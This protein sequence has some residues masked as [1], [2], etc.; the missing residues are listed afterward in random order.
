MDRMPVDELLYQLEVDPA[1]LILF[2]EGVRDQRF[3]SVLVPFSERINA[4]VYSIDAID[5]QIPSGGA[6]ERVLELARSTS[7]HVFAARMLFFLDAD[8][9][10][11][12]GRQLPARVITTDW[13]DMEAY[14]TLACCIEKVLYASGKNP[15]LQGEYRTTSINIARTVGLYRLAS[16]HL[17]LDLPFSSVFL[18]NGRRSLTNA[19]LKTSLNVADL[20][21]RLCDGA[22]LS[23]QKRS[24]LQNE[25]SKI[26]SRFDLRASE[27]LAHGKDF[28][29]IMSYMLGIRNNDCYSLLHLS[30]VAC[31]DSI[32]NMPNMLATE[33]F[34]RS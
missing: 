8:N 21:Q 9:D 34:L 28:C 30:I 6:R 33:N 14:A 3:Y 23:T 16:D 2:V 22:K 12:L 15:V 7:G 17:D 19:G 18:E 11:L 13:R 1:S 4:T 5:I 10:I 27:D 29:M 32:R 31:L 24:D 26:E 25:V 20:K